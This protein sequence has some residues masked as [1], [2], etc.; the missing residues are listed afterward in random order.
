LW[1][2]F[3]LLMRL[4]PQALPVVQT[5]QQV[6]ADWGLSGGAST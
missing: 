5:L 6:A 3:V 4:L 1:Q 2:A